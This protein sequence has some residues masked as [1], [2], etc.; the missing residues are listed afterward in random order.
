M[1][2]SKMVTYCC[3][4]HRGK[5]CL[6]K[7]LNSVPI[8]NSNTWSSPSGICYFY[9]LSHRNTMGN[10]WSDYGGSDTN[11]D[12]IGDTSTPYSTDS[13]GDSFP[14]MQ[15]SDN[16]TLQGWWLN[17]DDKMYKGNL[18][19]TAGTSQISQGSTSCIWISD[20]AATYNVTFSSGT[21]VGQLTFASAPG[22]GAITVQVG[23]STGDAEN[24]TQAVQASGLG[25]GNSQTLTFSAGPGVMSGS[26]SAG[27]AAGGNSS[28]GSG[29][30]RG[31]VSSSIDGC[32]VSS[33]S[34]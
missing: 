30:G 28:P 11:E 34:S 19:K 7:T 22:N 15:T 25:N 27:S 12:G 18:G 4:I 32:A 8:I 20:E 17:S 26:G 2:L 23:S 10:Y 33:G 14:L 24:F 1:W 31:A 6:C 21:W 16:Y 29:A 3:N 13:S 5:E 9:S